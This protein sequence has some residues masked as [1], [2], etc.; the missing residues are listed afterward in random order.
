MYNDDYDTCNRT[1]V[2]LR[3]YSDSLSPQE[4]T[5]YLGIEPSEIIE[6]GIGKHK[7]IIHNAWFLTSEDIVNSKDSRRHIDYLADKLLPIRERLEILASQG[8]EIDISC[9]W[10]SESGQGGPT[11]SPQQLSKLAELGIELWFDI[12]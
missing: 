4:I 3:L 6:K 11:F 9:F 2:T 12:Y 1:Y 10:L 8:A 5:N 7:S